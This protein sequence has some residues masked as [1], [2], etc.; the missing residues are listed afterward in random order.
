M[1]KWGSNAGFVL[2]DGYD[3]AGVSTALEDSVEAMTEDT[4]GIG[5][6][7]PEPSYVGLKQWSLTQ[8]GYFDDAAGSSNAALVGSHGAQRVASYGYEGNTVGKK[9][10]AAA[11]AVQVDY[12]R[13]VARGELHK[14]NAAYQGSGRVW[15]GVILH[16]LT[17]E[18]ANGNTEG[19]DSVDNLASSANGGAWFL[20][21]VALTLGGYTDLTVKLRHSADDITYADKDTATAVTAAPAAQARTVTGTINQYAACSWAFTGAGSGPSATFF[22][23][24]ARG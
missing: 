10:V 14:A 19:A 2:I 20:H 11:G 21:I 9:F 13:V 3:L 5:D 18:T 16:R 1:S 4:M 24:L 23:G 22:V 7:W 6:S 12:R 17:A 8:D 15:E